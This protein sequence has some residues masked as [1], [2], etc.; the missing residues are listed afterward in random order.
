MG[1]ELGPGV[2]EVNQL[3][4]P[5]TIRDSSADFKS[6]GHRWVVTCDGASHRQLLRIRPA[7][8]SQFPIQ[9]TI[10]ENGRVAQFLIWTNADA[11]RMMVAVTVVAATRDLI[12]KLRPFPLSCPISAEL[13]IH[14]AHPFAATTSVASKSVP[15]QFILF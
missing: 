1:K 7:S 8:R 10:Q 14:N 3:V 5:P 2:L 15:S 12:A 6:G 4:N 11:S 13:P 9:P